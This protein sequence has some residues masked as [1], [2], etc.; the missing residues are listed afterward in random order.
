[1]HQSLPRWEAARAPSIFFTKTIHTEI[2][3]R[4]HKRAVFPAVETHVIQKDY[5]S[6]IGNNEACFLINHFYALTADRD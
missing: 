2:N 3:A 1:M 4:R 6:W 5:E